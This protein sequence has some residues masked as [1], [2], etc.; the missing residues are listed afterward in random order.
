MP[1]PEPTI[2]NPEPTPTLLS[3]PTPTPAVPEPKP[4]TVLTSQV[5]PVKPDGTFIDD[6]RDFLP[7]E[8]RKDTSLDVIKTL[9]DMAKRMV[10]AVKMIGKNKI[11][12]PTD[13]SKP[14]EWDAF[15]RAIGRPEKEEAY[16][17]PEIPEELKDIF[18]TDRLERA[19]KRAFALA[20]T[21][22]QFD[23]FIKGEIE[24]VVQ[25]IKDSEEAEAKAKRETRL[26]AEKELRQ[27]LGAAY[28]ERMHIA[29][30]VITEAITK[31]AERVE[32]TEKYGDDVSIIRLLSNI[33]SRMSEHTALIAE[34]TQKT[35]TEIQTRIAQLNAT[36][37]YLQLNSA[38][39]KE[40]RQRIT[41]ELRELNKQLYPANKQAG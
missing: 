17:N 11:A 33:G 31:E 41:D 18:T 10:S 27:E 29:N 14:E 1:E 25:T 37:G 32:F 28:D 6:W 19:K 24:E 40:D 36:P 4:A 30:R 9:P 35:P 16:S 34:L 22:K 39:T 23:D 15:Y 12:L 26:N 8:I 13:K 21:Q 7:E 2:T 5:S 20:A 38:M 3:E